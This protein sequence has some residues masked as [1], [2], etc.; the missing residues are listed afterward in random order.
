MVRYTRTGGESMAVAIRIAR[1][2]TKK[3]KIAFAVIMDGTTGICHVI[4]M[5][6]II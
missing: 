3:D 1:A 4:S 2:F 6:M 5:E